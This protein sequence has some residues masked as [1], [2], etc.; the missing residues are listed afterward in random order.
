METQRR[1]ETDG[2]SDGNPVRTGVAAAGGSISGATAPLPVADLPVSASGADRPAKRRTVLA[3]SGSDGAAAVS[4][5]EAEEPPTEA[6]D[7]AGDSA[8]D[9]AAGVEEELG[10]AGD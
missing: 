9:S 6:A 3:S 5:A 10:A 1:A 4:R 2:I 8:S 7:A